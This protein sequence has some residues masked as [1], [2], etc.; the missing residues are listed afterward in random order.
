MA[1]K[2]TLVDTSVLINYYRKTDKANSVWVKLVRQGY[3]FSI[4]AVTKYE[5]YSGA[6]QNQLGFWNNVLQAIE[7]IAFDEVCVNTAV[8]VNAALKRKRKQIGIA[9]LFI[10]ATALTHNLPIATINKN[11]FD[12][13]D[14]LEIIE[15]E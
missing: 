4:S 5:I 10:A 15:I 9:D 1:D 11:H 6:T 8:D 14:G 12:R 7:V 13:I 2:I 3:R